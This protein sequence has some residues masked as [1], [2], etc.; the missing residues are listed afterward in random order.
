[1]IQTWPLRR[2]MWLHL[3]YAGTLLRNMLP[4]LVAV[5]FIFLLG[6]TAIWA[7]YD[8]GTTN[9]AAAVTY[10]YFLM[11]A[12]PVFPHPPENGLVQAVVF[13]APLVGIVVVFDLLARFSLHVFSKRTNHREWVNVVASTYRDHIVLCGLGRVGT[14]VFEELVQLG[15][16]VVCIER[17]EDAHG[18]RVARQ[19]DHPVLV[20]DARIDKV[21]LQ[22]GIRKAKAVLAVTDDDIVNLEIALDARK[23]NANIRV[24]A[25]VFNE[26]LGLKLTRNLAIDA[27]Y[28]TTSLAAPFF[29]IS[30]LDPE[31]IN[32]FYV[33]G[34]RFVVVQTTA[35]AGGPLD[36]R[37]VGHA[38]DDLGLAVM[39]VVRAGARVPVVSALIL[40]AGDQV[41][42]QGSYEALKRYR[43]ERQRS[44][45]AA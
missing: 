31:I 30:S 9:A 34:E 40:R 10:M 42:F 33:Q 36:G 2:R 22:A 3:A 8:H 6:T 25:R 32:S 23:Y 11:L 24:I 12:E 26:E 39:S 38:L 14:K 18:V 29:A 27:V 7:L 19:S 37:T 16:A 4:S 41:C 17:D 13:I 20:D 35:C 5:S 1:M 45:V 15:E 44:T 21:L 43:E 28:S